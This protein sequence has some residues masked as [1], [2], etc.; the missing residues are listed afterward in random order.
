MK[1]AITLVAAA[2]LVLCVASSGMAK[3][4]VSGGGADLKTSGMF[5]TGAQFVDNADFGD[6]DSHFTAGQRLRQY[7]D[8]IASE[9]LKATVGYE[10]NSVWG[11]GDAQAGAD[12]TGQLALKRANVSFTFPNSELTTKA[13]IQWIALPAGGLG[14]NPVMSGD[15]AG[16]TMSTPLTDTANLTFG[17]FRAYDSNKKE[18]DAIT[19]GLD[20][21]HAAVPINGDGVSAT[22]W[23][24]YGMI[25]NEALANEDPGDEYDY[26]SFHTIENPYATP[27]TQGLVSP[28]V[29]DTMADG[30]TS[31]AGLDNLLEDADISDAYWLGTNYNLT[32]MDPLQVKGS[33]IYGS[34]QA[35]EDYAERSGWYTDLEVDYAM[36][37]M[38]PTMFG[39]YATGDDDDFSDGSETMPYIFNDALASNVNSMLVGD[40]TELSVIGDRAGSTVLLQSTPV[41]LWQIGG[42]IKDIALTDKLSSTL[43]VAYYQGTNDY[44][45]GER[46]LAPGT[47]LSDEDS[48]YE[49]TLHSEYD[50]YENLTALM[51]AG[52]AETDYKNMSDVEKAS[53]SD[54][55]MAS[56]FSF[57]VQYN[58]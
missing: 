23:A 30:V 26:N 54:E 47:V 28:G 8:Y 34:V 2:A 43:L 51:N 20:V 11:S 38:T 56:K 57:G 58:F 42:G 14:Y 7:F 24:A 35:G 22:P 31:E 10:F 17:W 3:H 39:S 48:A 46:Y 41:G 37:T 18:E 19:P 52:I 1:K 27:K 25:G 5:I 40:R 32:M 13:G 50:I 4:V 44:K 55:E 9:N 29:A 45:N 21:L 12:E 16:V 53:M 49:V 15:A 6:E 33:L 36:D